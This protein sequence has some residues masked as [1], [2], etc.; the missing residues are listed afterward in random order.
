MNLLLVICD[1]YREPTLGGTVPL[2]LREILELNRSLDRAATHAS[3]VHTDPL[4]F[5]SED[6]K[7]LLSGDDVAS[8]VVIQLEQISSEVASVVEHVVA[9]AGASTEAEH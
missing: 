7:P 6:G 2:S 5:S 9:W 1:R 4:F 3:V 8:K